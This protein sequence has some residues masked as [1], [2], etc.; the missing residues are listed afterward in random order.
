MHTLYYVGDQFLY[1]VLARVI[2]ADHNTLPGPLG[3]EPGVSIDTCVNICVNVC[4]GL[5]LQ[6]RSGLGVH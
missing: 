5:G 4:V 3:V 6:V 2:Y 1:L